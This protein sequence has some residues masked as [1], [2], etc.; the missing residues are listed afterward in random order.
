MARPFLDAHYDPIENL[1]AISSCI[2][3][4]DLYGD[5]DQRLIIASRNKVMRIYRGARIVA[6]H[7]LQGAPAGLVAFRL[8]GV[9]DSKSLAVAVAANS[10]IFVYKPISGVLKPFQKFCLPQFRPTEE[11]TDIWTRLTRGVLTPIA[12]CQELVQLRVDGHAVSPETELLLSAPPDPT[13]V[14]PIFDEVEAVTAGCRREMALARREGL[15]PSP[16]IITAITVLPKTIAE[17]Q[18]CGQLVVGTE[19]GDIF[20][21][22]PN[23]RAADIHYRIK[24]VPTRIHVTG[25]R[26]VSFRIIAPCR[27]RAIY[28]ITDAGVSANVIRTEAD[29]VDVVRIGNKMYVATNDRRLTTYTARGRKETTLSLPADIVALE[30]YSVTAAAPVEGFMLCMSTGEVQVFRGP[31]VIARL[32]LPGPVKGIRML[33]FAREDNC[34]ISV[35][36]SGALDIKI[37]QRSTD[38]KGMGVVKE[39]DAQDVPLGIVDDSTTIH[40]MFKRETVAGKAAGLYKGFQLDLTQIKLAAL[41]TR[42]KSR[43]ATATTA[44]TSRSMSARVA[45]KGF[46]PSFLLTVTLTAPQTEYGLT[47]LTTCLAPDGTPV[48]PAPIDVAD[49][50]VAVPVV[51]TGI[52]ATVN[53]RLR[54]SQASEM[55]TTGIVRVIVVDA[56]REVL[57]MTEIQT[58]ELDP[59]IVQM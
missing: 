58:P 39:P 47:V 59:F 50:V 25:S 35:T 57:A 15:K 7:Q 27:D 28:S 20:I 51:M 14:I 11:E 43:K 17:H 49:P 40:S 9:D 22:S 52:T 53:V 29:I 37:L 21:L 5:N 46:G 3:S 32:Q 6:E 42:L 4:A 1:D 18:P 55:G 54:V 8:E 10:A 2:V 34:L 23:C 13:D 48:D 44:D 38:M 36:E 33:P 24:G 31:D 56:E 26:A 12:A 30:Q 19:A 16:S 45:L 41:A